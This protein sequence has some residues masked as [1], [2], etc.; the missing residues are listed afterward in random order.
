[1]NE[2]D[3][4]ESS[5]LEA[6]SR[7]FVV[8]ASTNT[9]NQGEELENTPE[10]NDPFSS[11]KSL[12]SFR[13]HFRTGNNTVKE[14]VPKSVTFRQSVYEIQEERFAFDGGKSVL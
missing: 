11:V 7:K 14:P 9:T 13:L 8:V 12:G 1:M 3:L 6:P 4:E 5:N 10:P 2:E